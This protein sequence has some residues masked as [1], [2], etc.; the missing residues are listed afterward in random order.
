[1]LRC[2][3]VEDR[4]SGGARSRLPQELTAS[5]SVRRAG[6]GQHLRSTE[7]CVEVVP[8]RET[9]G[10]Y[11]KAGQRAA[12][13]P[14]CWCPGVVC[15]ISTAQVAFGGLHGPL[16][17]P[18]RRS[19]AGVIPRI[20][21]DGSSAHQRL[22]PRRTSSRRSRRSLVGSEFRVHERLLPATRA[23]GVSFS[24][25]P[26]AVRAPPFETEERAPAHESR[27]SV[28]ASGT[29]RQVFSTSVLRYS[30][31]LSGAFAR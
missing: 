4:R 6:Q 21:G 8:A 11:S 13:R 22:A 1:M 19:Q 14:A 26:C 16:E 28:T 18:G 17:V 12:G 15:P 24:S 23:D 31:S 10:S 30:R 29:C 20:L 25:N 7:T 2:S 9:L 27:T 3:S 5:C